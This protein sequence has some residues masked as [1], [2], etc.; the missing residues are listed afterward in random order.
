LTLISAALGI[1]L[2][3]LVMLNLWSVVR[4]IIDDLKISVVKNLICLV[5]ITKCWHKSLS[6]SSDESRGFDWKVVFNDMLLMLLKSHLLNDRGGPSTHQLPAGRPSCCSVSV[7]LL[8]FFSSVR[9]ESDHLRDSRFFVNKILT[10][11]P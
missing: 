1:Q 4:R 9:L 2:V 6:C 10:V 3:A 7:Q 5:L 11:M 8:W